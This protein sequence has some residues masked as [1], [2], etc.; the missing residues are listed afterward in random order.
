MKK[1]VKHSLALCALLVPGLA[2]AA[3]FV[4]V[5]G[6][7]SVAANWDT[8]LV[9]GLGETA[10][11]YGGTV[12]VT[13]SGN[14][15]TI[16]MASGGSYTIAAGGDL[17]ASGQALIGNPGAGSLLVDGGSLLVGTEFALGV[18]GGN[19]GSVTLNSGSI[20]SLS[21][22]GVGWGGGSGTL[23]VNGGVLNANALDLG[24]FGGNGDITLNAGTISASAGFNA[25]VGT[26]TLVIN[27]G[28]MSALSLN[29]DGAGKVVDL[30]GGQLIATSGGFLA[31]TTTFNIGDGELIFGNA[32]KEDVDF[33]IDNTGTWNFD[34]TGGIRSVTQVGS[35]VVVTT[36]PEPSTM[37]L[38]SMTGIAVI[39]IRRLMM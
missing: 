10:A 15:G 21:L 39:A 13:T 26:G 34:G 8:G 28:V 20:T 25:S 1:H 17:T 2:M 22:L 37:A 38:M 24:A 33:L 16:L 14:L 27:G 5:T 30:N 35:D 31:G 18:G 12:T 36:I 6:D 4:P 3:N 29:F 19:S 9:P 32:A 7:Y 11:V 23:T